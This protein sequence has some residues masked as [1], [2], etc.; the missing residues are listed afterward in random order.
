MEDLRVRLDVEIKKADTPEPIIDVKGTGK[1]SAYVSITLPASSQRN[2]SLQPEEKVSQLYEITCP[3]CEQVHRFV[4][5]EN[6]L[7]AACKGN[8]D[9]AA[10]GFYVARKMVQD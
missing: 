7:G 8:P 6:G 2:L 9:L 4:L 1:C 5:N 3:F 10:S